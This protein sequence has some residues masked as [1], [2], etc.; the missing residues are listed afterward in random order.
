MQLE[1]VIE[2]YDIVTCSKCQKNKTFKTPSAVLAKLQICQDCYMAWRSG[3]LELFDT[4]SR[5]KLREKKIKKK[6]SKIMV[7]YKR[8]KWNSGR[9]RRLRRK[10]LLENPSCKKCGGKDRLTIHHIDK[11]VLK[12]LD[13]DNLEVMC[14][15]CHHEL[16]MAKK[17]VVSDLMTAK[18][19]KL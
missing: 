2:Y 7:S 16:R 19:G 14:W 12:T 9:G 4:G 10:T 8:N 6:I 13:E 17:K 1:E 11:D 15:D 3:Q 18:Y 5:E